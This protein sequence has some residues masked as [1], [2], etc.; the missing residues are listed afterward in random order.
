MTQPYSTRFMEGSAS[1]GSFVDSYE[2]PAGKRAIVRQLTYADAS[3]GGTGAT[4]A[5][6]LPGGVF[7]CVAS[8]LGA[9]SKEFSQLHLV[10]NAGETMQVYRA[11]GAAF[12]SV[13]GYL[14]D[15]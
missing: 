14:L 9:T 6:V 5:F 15:E 3:P 11:A 8:P 12:W 7:S 10:V 4:L 13:H 1:S 2:V